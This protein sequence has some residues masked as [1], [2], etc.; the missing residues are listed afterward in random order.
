MAK[1]QQ[2]FGL[3]TG[4]TAAWLRQKPLRWHSEKQFFILA[5]K[6]LAVWHSPC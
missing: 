6:F 2:R 4:M 1:I 3:G 5:C